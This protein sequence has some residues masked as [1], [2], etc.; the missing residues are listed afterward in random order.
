MHSAPSVIFPV[1]RSRM[2]RRLLWS[3]WGLGAAVLAVWCVQFSGSAWR[4]ALLAAVLPLS[5]CAALAASRMGQESRLQCNVLL[6]PCA[7]SAWLGPALATVHLDLQS[8]VLVR[9]LESGRAAAWF[10]LER[11]SCPERWLDLRRA[12]HAAG[13]HAAAAKA[14]QL[15]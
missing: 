5:A 13:P 12:L 9:L 1:G 11:A 4:T 7:A 6:C 3:V 14:M 10:W 15:P 8:L 2:A